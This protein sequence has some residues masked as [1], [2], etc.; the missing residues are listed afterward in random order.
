[1][2]E[3]VVRF[4]NAQLEQDLTPIFD[5]YLRRAA[6]PML[7]LAFDEKAGTVA[8]RWKADERAFAMPIR[9]GERGQW[10]TIQPT[11][12]WKVMPNSHAE[13]RVRGRDRPL[14]RRCGEAVRGN[15]EPGFSPAL[16]M[17]TNRRS[18]GV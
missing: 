16:C 3:D 15:G 10:Q 4:F 8:Y 14:L 7:E 5:Q 12:D 18:S 17:P 2:T 11:T 6:L 13:G 1:M 9:V